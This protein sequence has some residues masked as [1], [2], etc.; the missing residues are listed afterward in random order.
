[1]V[2]FLNFVRLDSDELQLNYESNEVAN[3]TLVMKEID[4]VQ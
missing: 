3:T 4:D 1:M 2:S